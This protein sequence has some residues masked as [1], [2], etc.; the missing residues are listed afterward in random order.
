M[1]QALILTD[2][3]CEAIKQG[4]AVHVTDSQSQLECVLVRSDVY[5]R[6]RALLFDDGPLSPEEKLAA[7]RA[8][9]LRANWDD[10]ALDV[11]EQYRRDP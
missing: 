11:Y 9:G 6:L 1:G 5:D 4:Q 7:I 10:P 2:E 3:Q 8:A